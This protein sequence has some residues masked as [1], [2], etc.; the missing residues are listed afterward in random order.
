[1]KY[2]NVYFL[3]TPEAKEARKMK[4]LLNNKMNN[5][6]DQEGNFYKIVEGDH[7]DYR[8]E[9]LKAIDKGAFG[10]ALRCF[11]YKD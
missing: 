7:L 10:Q 4:S 9:V 11:D 2:S 3:G 8:F 6:F 1:L 5:G